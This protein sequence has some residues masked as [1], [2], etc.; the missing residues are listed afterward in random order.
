MR[1]PA[2]APTNDAPV[3]RACAQFASQIRP[4]LPRDSLAVVLV[5]PAGDTSRVVYSW[6]DAKPSWTLGAQ[7]VADARG[8]SD[9]GCSLRIPLDSQKGVLGEVL[10]KACGPDVYNES[11]RALV[12][13]S[14][15]A[16][17]VALENITLQR[18]LAALRQESEVLKRL[19]DEASS[20]VSLYQMLRCFGREIRHLAEYHRLTIFLVDQGSELLVPVFQ[21]GRRRDETNHLARGWIGRMVSH[22]ET[23]ILDDLS[24]GLATDIWEGDPAPGYRSAILVPVNHGGR[25]VGVVAL[26]HRQPLAYGSEDQARLAAVSAALGPTMYRSAALPAAKGLQADAAVEDMIGMLSASDDLESGFQGFAA[27]LCKSLSFDVAELSWIDPNG[28]DIRTVSSAAD[29]PGVQNQIGDRYGAGVSTKLHNRG[30]VVGALTLRRAKGRGFSVRKQ[31]ALDH[32]GG[33]ISPTIQSSRIYVHARG[34]AHQLRQMSH[35]QGKGQAGSARQLDGGE[36]TG[37][38]G[39][40]GR[41]LLVDIAHSF[42]TPLTSIKV[43]SSTLLQS[44]VDWP[45]ET[46]Q[47]FIRLIDQETDRLGRMVSELLVPG[48]GEMDQVEGDPGSRTGWMDIEDLFEEA[49]FQLSEVMPSLILDFEKSGFGQVLPPVPVGPIGMARVICYLVAA[50]ARI[51]DCS[52]VWVRAAATGGR[53]VITVGPLGAGGE[54][55][56]Q[57][58]SLGEGLLQLEVCRAHLEAHGQTLGEGP[59]T[60]PSTDPLNQG[61]ESFWFYLP[62]EAASLPLAAG[63]D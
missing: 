23:R 24:E 52:G 29:P 3:H 22:G 56:A 9:P 11:R 37:A 13:E 31:S 47:E 28:L 12:E 58:W 10:A 53:P 48:P 17:A 50:T 15:G 41:D 54:T 57:P 46:Q 44:D 36:A 40:M 21:P 5:E 59:L 25:T 32:I 42:R 39:V 61:G 51:H 19:V 14:A 6:V 34:Q 18:Q 49:R 7:V 1:N 43:V 35:T 27:A 30:R 8:F 60:D 16:L 33:Q 38:A 63:L 26:E 4:V 55:P 62:V 2:F 45:P 20:G